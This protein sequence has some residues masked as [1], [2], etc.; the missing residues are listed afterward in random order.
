MRER[1]RAASD[2]ASLKFTPPE[3]LHPPALAALRGA[4]CAARA[5]RHAGGME[6][7]SW[8]RLTDELGVVYTAAVAW[9]EAPALA[10]AARSAV[11]EQAAQDAEQYSDDEFEDRGGGSGVPSTSR[12]ACSP[13]LWRRHGVDVR[14]VLNCDD[15][16]PLE[17]EARPPSLNEAP[18]SREPLLNCASPARRRLSLPHEAGLSRVTWSW[19]TLPTRASPG[20]ATFERSSPHSGGSAALRCSRRASADARTR[21]AAPTRCAP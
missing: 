21:V 20:R 15:L 8:G 10:A 11:S 4:G 6:V 7:V 5:C 3:R 2:R 18:G 17:D 1:R 9:N 13:V 16:S 19:A 14:A 12:A